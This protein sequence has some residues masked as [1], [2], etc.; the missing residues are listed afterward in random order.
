MSKPNENILKFMHRRPETPKALKDK[1]K[2][3]LI[4]RKEN[5]K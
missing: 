2:A 1:I 3:A 5:K 4:K